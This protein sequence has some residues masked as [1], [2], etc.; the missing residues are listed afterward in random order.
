MG[1]LVGMAF[2][3]L[4]RATACAA[5]ALAARRLAAGA[6]VLAVIGL[7]AM[8][9]AELARVVAD[10][11]RALAGI[12][13]ELVKVVLVAGLVGVVTWSFR[14]VWF[15]YGG[16]VPALLPASVATL[17]PVAYATTFKPIWSGL[18]FAI[19]AAGLAGVIVPQ[20]HPIALAL[21]AGGVRAV[22]V[23]QVLDSVPGP[24]QQEE[25]CKP[26]LWL[27]LTWL[28]RCWRWWRTRCST[29]IGRRTWTRSRPCRCTRF[30][31]SS[32]STWAPALAI[33]WPTLRTRS[34]LRRS[35]S[36]ARRA[37][38][39]SVRDWS[40]RPRGA[41]PRPHECSWRRRRFGTRRRRRCWVLCSP[42]RLRTGMLAIR[43]WPWKLRVRRP[44]K[45]HGSR[46]RHRGVDCPQ[47]GAGAAGNR[48][49][50]ASP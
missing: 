24:G 37:R 23:L 46:E 39:R 20:L 44:Q 47:R 45:R 41:R 38:K 10:M 7:V 3:A 19:T 16:D 14:A 18:V 33:F 30:R 36:I 5:A 9:L 26:S 15:A 13:A 25:T 8:L 49:A 2:D 43:L 12:S 40:S 11:V 34:G 21:L 6:L 27:S 17:L 48:R 31:L 35:A 4:V 1:A 42:W 50:L 29:W 32:F 28:G 22:G